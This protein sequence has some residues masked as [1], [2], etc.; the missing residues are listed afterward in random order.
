MGPAHFVPLVMRG[1]T[2]T[3]HNNIVVCS[4]MSLTTYTQYSFLPF[5]FLKWVLWGT[6]AWRKKEFLDYNLCFADKQEGV[7]Y[8]L[9]C[10]VSRWREEG[11]GGMRECTILCV[12]HYYVGGWRATQQH[13]YLKSYPE[14]MK[15]SD[16]VVFCYHLVLV[17]LPVYNRKNFCTIHLILPHFA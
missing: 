16:V 11:V 8:S 15:C 7:S 5:F 2:A 17:Y 12:V 9:S 4:S 13:L 1:E 14:C 6:G 3:M 10:L